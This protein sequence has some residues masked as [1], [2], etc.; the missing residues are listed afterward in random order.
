V[1][2]ADVSVYTVRVHYSGSPKILINQSWGTNSI[3][4]ITND[5]CN[6]VCVTSNADNLFNCSVTSIT[7]EDPWWG[8]VLHIDVYVNNVL[9]RELTHNFVS[10]TNAELSTSFRIND[11]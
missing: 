10:W 3:S 1:T 4:V 5:Q 8:R 6:V 11:L 2:I 9:H 7:N